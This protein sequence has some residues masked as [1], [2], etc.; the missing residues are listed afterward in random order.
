MH[1]CSAS[2]KACCRISGGTAALQ[3]LARQPGASKLIGSG[4]LH[5]Q[6]ATR[7]QRAT[8]NLNSG[9]RRLNA[10]MAPTA[11]T[12]QKYTKARG[13]MQL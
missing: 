3:V 6:L 10:R 4:P 9:P 8:C 2:S 11:V 12:C 1:A 7:T 13:L 5:P